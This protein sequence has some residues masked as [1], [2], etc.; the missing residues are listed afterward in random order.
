[1]QDTLIVLS[2][3]IYGISE[4]RRALFLFVYAVEGSSVDIIVR[5]HQS[6]LRIKPTQYNRF[7]SGLRPDVITAGMAT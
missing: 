3:F 5:G 4:G 6:F 7:H 2:I 1:M